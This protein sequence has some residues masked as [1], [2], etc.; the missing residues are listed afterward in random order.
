MNKKQIYILSSRGGEYESEPM[1]KSMDHQERYLTTVFNFMGI[2]DI[3]FIR[4]EGISLGEEKKQ[5]ALLNAYQQIN[6]IWPEF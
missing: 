2:S 1:L 5:K 4:A 3:T 6:E